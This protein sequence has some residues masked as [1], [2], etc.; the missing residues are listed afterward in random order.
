MC[1]FCFFVFGCIFCVY[2]FFCMVDIIFYYFFLGVMGDYFK[3]KFGMVMCVGCGS[4][5]YD[6]FILWVLFD[7][8]W[9][10]VCF[11]CVECS[12]Y[13]D[14]MCMCF[15]RDGKIYCKWDY[16][17][18]FGIKCVKCQVGFSSSDL[19]MRVWDSVYYIECFCCFVCSCQLL[20]GDEFLLWEYELFCCVDYGFLFECVVVGSLCSFGLFFGFCGLYLLD[21]GLG[22]QFVLCLYVYKQMEKMI[23]V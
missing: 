3:K 22:W 18:L 9:Y 15:V 2:F 16:V 19:V 17:R 21:V 6:Q 4:Q 8:E 11:K 10:V 23:C 5:I 1:D 13:L 20:F 12:Q 7:F 14:E